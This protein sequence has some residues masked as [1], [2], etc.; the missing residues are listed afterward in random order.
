[1]LLFVINIVKNFHRDINIYKY[2]NVIFN[3]LM[4]GSNLSYE[5]YVREIKN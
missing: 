2:K 4:I 5:S 1:M 3:F